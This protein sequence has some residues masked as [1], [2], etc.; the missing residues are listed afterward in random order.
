MDVVE[1]LFS[2]LESNNLEDVAR[3]KHR[4]TDNFSISK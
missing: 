1:R 3:A 4:L 2:D